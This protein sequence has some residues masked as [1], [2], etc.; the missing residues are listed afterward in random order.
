MKQHSLAACT[1]A[2]TGLERQHLMYN[3][4]LM[5]IKKQSSLSWYMR[6]E[7]MLMNER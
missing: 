5:M 7:G 1:P 4:R 3:F 2:P 6:A